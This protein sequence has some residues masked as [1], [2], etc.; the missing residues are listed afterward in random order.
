MLSLFL[1]ILTLLK[2]KHKVAAIKA[3]AIKVLLQLIK[4]VQVEAEANDEAGQC[5]CMCVVGLRS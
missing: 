3:G 4:G 2:S 5:V 1:L